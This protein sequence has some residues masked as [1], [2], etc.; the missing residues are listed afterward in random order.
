[1]ELPDVR[2]VEV[3]GEIRHGGVECTVE[4]GVIGA[5]GLLFLIIKSEQSKIS[6]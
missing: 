2:A 3:G 6:L 1:M 4:G 5:L